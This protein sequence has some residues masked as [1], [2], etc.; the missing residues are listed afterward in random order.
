MDPKKFHSETIR[1]RFSRDQIE[2]I[3]PA[4]H[5]AC[6]VMESH[7]K[8]DTRQSGRYNLIRLIE[9]SA[10]LN[11]KEVNFDNI[12]LEEKEALELKCKSIIADCYK[13]R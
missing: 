2:T 1:M 6:S 7:K 3:S 4:L 5:F 8:Q 12:S 10:E 11:L 9:R 13:T